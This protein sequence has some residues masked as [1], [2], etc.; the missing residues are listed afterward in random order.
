MIGL[1]ICPL[2]KLLSVF[3]RPGQL[4]ACL[5]V[6]SWIENVISSASDK[7]TMAR[8]VLSVIQ[9]PRSGWKNEGLSTSRCVDMGWMKI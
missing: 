5:L 2:D 9:S 3:A 6:L 4:Y 8:G 1:F 7:S